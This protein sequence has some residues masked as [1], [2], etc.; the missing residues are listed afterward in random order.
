[1]TKKFWKTVH[2]IL[3]TFLAAM[4]VLISLAVW[5]FAK[6]GLEGFQSLWYGRVISIA[7]GVWI[8]L[9]V[10]FLFCIIGVRAHRGE[11]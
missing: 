9:L 10:I 3:Y 2:K 1:M 7:S 11:F 4:V 8:S 5:V 6:E